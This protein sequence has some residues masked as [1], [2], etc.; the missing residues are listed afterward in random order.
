MVSQT[1]T[2]SIKQTQNL[3]LTPQM[4]QS[5]KVL[6]LSVMDLSQMIESEIENNPLL[7]RA[8]TFENDEG[9]EANTRNNDDNDS[10]ENISSEASNKENPLDGDFESSWNAAEEIYNPNSSSSSSASQDDAGTIIEKTYNKEISL[11]DHIEEQIHLDFDQPS[12]KIIALHLTDMLDSSGYL[13]AENLDKELEIL[14]EKLG[15]EIDEINQVISKLQTF[16]PLG[17]FSRNINECLKIQLREIDHLDPPME[18]LI[19]NLDLLAKG[20][21][22]RLKNICKTDHEELKEM[23]AEI[24]TLNPRPASDF[25]DNQSEVKHPDLKLYYESEQWKIEV[26]NDSLPAVS[27]N[28]EYYKNLKQKDLK[29]DEKEYLKNNYMSA[30]SLIKAVNQ[31]AKTMLRVGTVIASRQKDFFEKGINFLKPMSVKD[32]SEL[33]E[34]HESTIGRVISNKY[35]ETPLGVFELRYFFGRSLNATYSSEEVSSETAKHHIKEMIEAE[36]KILSD[37]AISKALK[38]RGIDIARRTVAK[39]REAMGIPTS[40]ERKRQRK[41]TAE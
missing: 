7:E 34:L 26:N 29:S 6:Q 17:V 36:E 20:E 28:E 11:K 38:K 18:K 39:Y 21:I 25:M 16:D 41:I 8:E 9:K 35:I 4:Q 15:C 33:L 10:Y 31:R 27:V 1:Q 19:D 40:A 23:I 22:N 37:E 12:E 5:L 32:V 24:R 2:L 14:A 30:N 3:A 13:A